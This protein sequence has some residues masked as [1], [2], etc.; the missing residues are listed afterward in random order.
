MILTLELDNKKIEV[1]LENFIYAEDKDKP[2]KTKYYD[3][4][5]IPKETWEGIEKWLMQL[6]FLVKEF[7][8]SENT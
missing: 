6:E 2:Q 7:P 8:L 4:P 1:S 5:D 3:A